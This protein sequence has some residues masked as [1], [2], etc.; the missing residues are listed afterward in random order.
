M[1]T[2]TIATLLAK[3]FDVAKDGTITLKRTALPS[4][5]PQDVADWSEALEQ[6]AS[7]DAPVGSG[8]EM[9]PADFTSPFALAGT[10]HKTYE[11]ALEQ[12]ASY[13]I[14]FGATKIDAGGVA[15][16]FRKADGV[17]F[18]YKKW[19]TPKD[20]TLTVG[21]IEAADKWLFTVEGNNGSGTFAQGVSLT[22]IG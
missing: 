2:I 5:T 16:A 3:C 17:G 19:E 12:G 13:L 22:K 7:S 18:F 11:V 9:L 6:L 10:E 20:D 21:P 4:A 15:V 1:A 8:A 14:R